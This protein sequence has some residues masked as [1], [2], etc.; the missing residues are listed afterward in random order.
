MIDYTATKI[1]VR[2]GERLSLVCF[3]LLCN[4]SQLTQHDPRWKETVLA[5]L[6]ISIASFLQWA[7]CALRVVAGADS[8]AKVH[9]RLVPFIG[10]A[11][12]QYLF[13][14]REHLI[15]IEFRFQVLQA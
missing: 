7:T 12:R 10:L 5:H 2:A 8:C 3:L 13:C 1:A 9:Q 6:S 4:L 15:M 11:I 14:Q